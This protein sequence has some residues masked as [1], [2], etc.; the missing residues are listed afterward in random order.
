MR[1]IPALRSPI[2][3]GCQRYHG[4]TGTSLFFTGS[5][6]EFSNVTTSRRPQRRTRCSDFSDDRI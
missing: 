6:A 3:S 1:H 2:R 5:T 4:M